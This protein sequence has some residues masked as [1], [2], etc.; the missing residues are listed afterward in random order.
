MTTGPVRLHPQPWVT[1]LYRP[2]KRVHPS[3]YPT[4]TRSSPSA[5]ALGMDRRDGT[6]RLEWTL[7]PFVNADGCDPHGWWTLERG[8][9][10]DGG[11]GRRSKR[12]D[13]E[14]AHEHLL[15]LPTTGAAN[16]SESERR[17]YPN[18]CGAD[19]RRHACGLNETQ[20]PR[21]QHVGLNDA[22]P[23]SGETPYIAIRCVQWSAC[24]TLAQSQSLPFEGSSVEALA[25]VRARDRRPSD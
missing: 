4:G 15:P 5:S 9:V 22:V 11:T 16:A 6:L 24:C 10:V 19:R 21:I 8:V 25:I 13:E 14:R 17:R 20:I 23:G 2:R 3:G 18:A 1:L 7:R 12:R